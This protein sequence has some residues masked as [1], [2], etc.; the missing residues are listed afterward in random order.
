MA[1]ADV[2]PYDYQLYGKEIVGY[3]DAAQQPRRQPPA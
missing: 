3:L 2:L 1:D